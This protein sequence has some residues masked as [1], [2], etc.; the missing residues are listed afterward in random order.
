MLPQA[1]ASLAGPAGSFVDSLV[2]L[3]RSWT[4]LKSLLCS[5]FRLS[6][7]TTGPLAVRH[8]AVAELL[9]H[10]R[11]PCTDMQSSDKRTHSKELLRPFERMSIDLAGPLP[12][13]SP[14]VISAVDHASRWVEVMPMASKEPE[15][16]IWFVE[17]LVDRYGYPAVIQ[18]DNVA[19]LTHPIFARYC[20]HHDIEQVFTSAR[21]KVVGGKL[22]RHGEEYKK[23][24]LL[25]VGAYRERWPEGVAAATRAYRFSVNKELGTSPYDA[26]FGAVR[27]D[28]ARASQV[29]CT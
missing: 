12:G 28:G 5:M 29:I 4:L 16:I 2:K 13:P 19:E 23:V 1:L 20:Q 26:I 27:G 10:S 25:V 14:Y 22:G 8:E 21:G 6:T 9:A 11:G 17:R 24:L 3:P 18:A 15:R 7:G